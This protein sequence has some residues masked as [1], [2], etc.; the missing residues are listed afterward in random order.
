[1]IEVPDPTD[2]SLKIVGFGSGEKIKPFKQASSIKILVA[3]GGIQTTW[4]VTDFMLGR[5]TRIDDW[6]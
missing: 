1:M 3:G 2:F 5:G 4:F 6:R